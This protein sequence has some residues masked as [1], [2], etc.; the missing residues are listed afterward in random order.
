VAA[1]AGEDPTKVVQALHA[2][3][4]EGRPALAH[5]L[6]KRYLTE[7][8]QGCLAEE[9]LALAIEAAIEE[10]PALAANYARRYLKR[11]PQGR[12]KKAAKRAVAR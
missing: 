5:N 7:H 8:P 6:L 4:R 12:Y 2:L 11:F 1:A 9:A 3:R 10:N